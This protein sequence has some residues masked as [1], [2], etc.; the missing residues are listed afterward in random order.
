MKQLKFLLQLFDG[1]WSVPL[2][3]ALFWLCGIMLQNIFGYTTGVYDP[4]FIQ[5]LLLSGAIVIGVTNLSVLGL[6]FTFRGLFRF[7]Y[8]YKK[9]G[10][11]LNESKQIWQN[12]TSWQKYLLAFSVFFLQRWLRSRY[13]E[14]M[15]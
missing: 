6:Y 2:A 15:H 5:P 14:H 7:F 13:M 11:I 12:I 9:E 8:G 10:E 3:F 1:I 4:S